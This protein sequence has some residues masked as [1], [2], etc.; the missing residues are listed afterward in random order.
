LHVLPFAFDYLSRGLEIIVIINH[1]HS[2]SRY[3]F[4]VSCNTVHVCVLRLS[5]IKSV[6]NHHQAS[7]IKHQVKM[8][9][10]I[11]INNQTTTYEYEYRPPADPALRIQNPPTH[12]THTHDSFKRKRER[13][14]KR[15]GGLVYALLDEREAGVI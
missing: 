8:I 1:R 14:R 10:S 7:S 9:D 4:A 13:K 5:T 6:I 15:G 11:S 2:H 12:H 3:W